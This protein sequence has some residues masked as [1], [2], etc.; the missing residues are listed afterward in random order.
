MRITWCGE[1]G[2]P[3]DDSSAGKRVDPGR[4]PIVFKSNVNWH[5][6]DSGLDC[7]WS[8]CHGR[9]YDFEVSEA[10]P[11]MDTGIR[12]HGPDAER[13]MLRMYCSQRIVN[14]S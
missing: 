12:E 14:A 6:L 5:A 4:T 3:L 13:S 2:D 10:V 7:R 11:A 8:P 1:V 9:K